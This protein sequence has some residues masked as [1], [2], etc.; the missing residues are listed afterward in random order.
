MNPKRTHAQIINRQ[1]LNERITCITLRP[2][3]FI[4]YESGQYLDII[5][6]G[7]RLSYSIATAPLGFT[8]Y[9]LHIRNHPALTKTNDVIIE[10]PFGDCTLKA[11]E[12]I[13][14]LIFIAGGTGFAP[15]HAMIQQLHAQ[16]D[17]RP[18]E[19]YWNVRSK[20]DLYFQERINTWQ[21]TLSSFY[22]ISHISPRKNNTGYKQI[23]T[24]HK[25]NLEQIQIVLAG[26]FE[27]VYNI[28]DELISHGVKSTQLFSDAFSFEKYKT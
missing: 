23:I 13:K 11:L 22:Y 17:P 14:P 10:L 21:T 20:E 8:T 9:D 24:R 26:P 12:P 25:K 16:H 3:E 6:E 28:R 27:M 2:D 7:E 4:A 18:I 5:L 19:L 15:V 1:P